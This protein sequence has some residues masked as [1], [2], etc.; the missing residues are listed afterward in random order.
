[1][2]FTTIFS[3]AV[4]A[5]GVVAQNG[6]RYCAGGAISCEYQKGRCAV[7]CNGSHT[8]GSASPAFLDPLCSCPDGQADNK[9]TGAACID[10]AR[11]LGRT[12]C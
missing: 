9:Y 3:I 12:N 6:Q 2:Q 1:M 11:A 7:I 8:S 10:I 5:L 4:L